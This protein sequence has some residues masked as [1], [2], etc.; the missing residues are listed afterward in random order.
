MKIK[1]KASCGS[2]QSNDCLV[3]VSPSEKLEITI[4]S[5]VFDKFGHLIRACV[6]QTLV[7]CFIDQANILV[8]D[9]GAL[10]YTIR[11]RLITAIGR[12]NE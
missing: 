4:N 11:A 1:R 12:S 3:T 10:D 5:T 8:E 9:F 6:D 2:M 7:D